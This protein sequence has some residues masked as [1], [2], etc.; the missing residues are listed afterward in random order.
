MNNPND[1]PNIN[2]HQRHVLAARLAW[3]FENNK[4]Q[5]ELAPLSNC[6]REDGKDGVHDGTLKQADAMDLQDFA[7][8]LLERIYTEPEKLKLAEARRQKRREESQ[9]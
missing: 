4:L 9:G 2:K 7:R 6:I 3:L 8:V 5:A 1:A